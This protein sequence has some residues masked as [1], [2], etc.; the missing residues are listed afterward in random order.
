M[1]DH[2]P[3]MMNRSYSYRGGDH[4][5]PCWAHARIDCSSLEAAERLRSHA[6]WWRHGLRSIEAIERR[7]QRT[8]GGD[9][10]DTKRDTRTGLGRGRAGPRRPHTSS[11]T[12]T[13][14][15][16]KIGNEHRVVRLGCPHVI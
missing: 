16:F 6:A 8:D 2:E 10:A 4:Y 1:S 15:E 7:R 11:G 5:A 9:A 3:P 13:H 12:G 14:R